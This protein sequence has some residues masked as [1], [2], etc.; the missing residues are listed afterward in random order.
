LYSIIAS[1][2]VAYLFYPVFRWIESKVKNSSLASVLTIITV[3]LIIIIPSIFIISTLIQEV[4]GIY[5][6]FVTATQ[7]GKIDP[8]LSKISQDFGVDIDVTKIIGGFAT[9]TLT[10]LQQLLTVLP[11]KILNLIVGTFFMYFYFKE[12]KKMAL[13]LMHYLPFGVKNS[14]IILEELK[15]TTDAVVYGQIITASIQFILATV[16][17]FLLGIKSPL[18]FA[19]MLFFFAVIPMVGPAFVYVP[20]GVLL[21]FSPDGSVLKG[22][23]LLIFGFGVISS[24]DN[25]V[26]PIVISDK[27][28]LHT[29]AVLISM[30][31]GLA[32]FGVLGVVLGPIILTLFVT[33]FNIYELR[34]EMFDYDE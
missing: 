2:I 4:P 6:S 7:A 30:I 23:I 34:A 33:L 15:K 9:K 31:G 12:G 24:V 3:Y 1:A 27:M 5:G 22:V 10:S 14:K 8:Y 29:A 26:K 18:F 21:L 19:V 13:L 28:K 11:V 20:L 25:I 17:F 16:M 32:V